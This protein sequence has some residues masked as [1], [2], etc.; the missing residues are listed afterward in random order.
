[1]MMMNGKITVFHEIPMKLAVDG[2]FSRKA[3]WWDFARHLDRLDAVLFTRI[4]NCSV[5]GMASVLHRKATASVYPQIGHFF[6]NLEERRALASPDGDKDSDPLLVSLLQTGSDM[7]TDLRHLNLKPQLCYRSPDPINLY[8]KVGHG[9]LDMYVL[10]PSKDSKYVREFLKRWHNSEQKLFEGASISGQF[11]FPI[12]NLVSI[13]A[14]LVWRPANPDDTITR[15]MFPG[16]TPQHK[17]FEGL[18]KLRHL[19]FLQHPSYTGRQML[20]TAPATT[21]TTVT[22]S[23]KPSKQPLTKV[24]KERSIISERKDEKA[25]DT[26][27]ITSKVIKDETDSKNIIDNKLLSE[28]VDGYD[29]KIE[30][31]LHEAINARVDTKL[32]D[33]F[34]QYESTV[35]DGL[36][37]KKDLK[38]KVT[39]K[40]SKRT[41][42]TD[43][44]KDNILK[45]SELKKPEIDKPKT[46]LRKKHEKTKTDTSTTMIKSKLS[47]RTAMKSSDKKIT[48][49]TIDRKGTLDDKKSPPTTP[50]KIVDM[51]AVPTPLPV[52]DKVRVKTR[53]VSP[54]STPAKSTKEAN[55]RRVVESKYKQGSPKRDLTQKTQDKK[56]PKIKRE[57][58]SRRPRPIASPIK[59]MKALKSPSK[60][61]KTM[62]ADTSKLKGLQRVNYEDILKEAKKS[63]EDTSKSL[64]DIKQ[65]ELDEREEQEIVREI[66][67]V[68]NRDSE[69]EEKNEFVGRSDIEKI[70]CLIDDAKTETIADGDFEEE[71]LIIEKEEVDQYTE[72]SLADKEGVIEVEGEL[73]KHMKDKEESEKIKTEEHKDGVKEI[74]KTEIFIEKEAKGSESKDQ[75]ISVE[76]K[77]DIS[78]EKKTSETKSGFAKPK[79]SLENIVQES[80]PDEKIST[81]IESGATTAP[82]LPE[83]E[84]IPLDDIKED[85]QVEEKH[86]KED[87]KEIMHQQALIGFHRPVSIEK[88][89]KKEPQPTPIREI[90]KTPDEVADLPLHEEVDYRIY[91]EKKTPGEEDYK[92]KHDIGFQ[93]GI[94]VPND[95]PLFDKESSVP[96]KTIQDDIIVQTAQRP[97]HAELVTVTPGSAPESPMYHEQIKMTILSGQELEPVKEYDSSAFNYG[98]YTEKLRETHITTVHSPIKDDLALTEEIAS[99]PVK[100]PSIPE[101]VE[102]EIEE[103]SKL[104][105]SEKPLLSP[106][107][108]E[109]IVADVAE[110]LKSDKSLDELIAEKSPM[111]RKS[112]EIFSSFN[113][114]D[115]AVE[116]IL[117]SE[118]DITGEK[119]PIKDIKFTKTAE[120]V[121]EEKIKDELPA[122]D[123]LEEDQRIGKEISP[124]RSLTS[125]DI[126]DL[127][128]KTVL[129]ESKRVKR[130]TK[131]DKEKDKALETTTKSSTQVNGFGANA[132]KHVQTNYGLDDSKSEIKLSVTLDSAKTLEKLEEKIAD[133]KKKEEKTVET[134]VSAILLKDDKKEVVQKLKED[135]TIET[136]ILKQQHETDLSKALEKEPATE[137]EKHVML[138]K[139]GEI[140]D[141]SLEITTSIKNLDVLANPDIIQD[142]K[143]YPKPISFDNTLKIKSHIDSGKL[144]DK[145][146][147]SEK[148]MTKISKDGEKLSKVDDVISPEKE[149]E[150]ETTPEKEVKAT[151]PVKDV[152]QLHEDE[153][154]LEKE[155]SPP[156]EE[157]SSEKVSPEKETKSP[158]LITDKEKL[159]V[160]A[161]TL[162]KEPSPPKE[163]LSP[164]KESEREAKPEKEA[165]AP[166]PVKDVD[167]LHESQKTLEKEPSPPKEILSSEKVSPE[168]KTISPSPITEIEKLSFA[169]EQLGK[170]PSPPKD[171]ISPE[172]ESE[173][174]TTPEKEVKATTP[175][176]DVDQLHEDEKPLEK[177]P[178]PPKEEVNKDVSKLHEAEKPLEKEPSPPKE[179]LSSEKVSPEKETKSPSPI[180]EKEKLS[181]AEEPLGKEPSP[182]EAKA[183]TPV[184]DVGKLHEAK[185]PLEKEPSPPKEVVSFEK[186]SPEMKTQSLSPFT[187]KEKLHVADKTLGKEQSPPKDVL[188][189]EKESEKKAIPEKETK[190]PTPVKDVGKLHEAK[191]PLEKEPSP[192]KEV[193]SSEKGSPEKETKSPSPITEKENLSVAEEPLGKEPSP[194]KEVPRPKK[195]SE[196]EVTPEKEAKEPTSVKDVGK[197]R[198]AEIPLE[199]EPS[200]PKEVLSSEKGSP[201]KETKSPKKL[202]LAE[203]PLEMEPSPPKEVLRTEK[204]SPGKETKSPCPITEKENLSVAEEPLGKEPSPPKEVLSPEK[205]SEREAT[206]EKEAKEPT[207]VKDVGELHETEKALEKEP[208]PPT[209]VL[210]FEKVS[211]EKETKSPSPIT[212][213][214]KLP[215]AEEPL[216]K[217]PSLPKEVPRPKKESER[218]V[219]PEK[220][221]KEPTSVKAV[222]KLHES[223]KTLEKEPSTPKEVLRTEKVLPEK[224]TKSPSPITEKE[225]LPLAEKPLEMEP[226][227]P[228]E[229]LSSEKESPGKETKSPRPITEKENLSVA[230]EP[231]GKEPSPPKEVLGPEKESEREATPKKE[232]KETTPVKDVGELHETEKA[233]EKKPSPPKDVLSS[234]KV[235][236]EKETK[237]PSPITEKEKLPL[238]EEPLEKEQSLPKEVVSSEKVS[239]ENETKSPSPIMEKEKLPVA[240]APLG[241]EISP[242]KEL[243]SPEKESEKKTTPEKEAKAPTPDKDVSKLHEAE[244]P[245]EKEPSPPK[246]ALSSKKGSP[247][248]EKKSPSPILEKEKLPVAEEPLGKE[249]SPPKE[250]PGPKKES[251]REVTPEKE[252][253][254]PTSVKDVG[255]LHESPKTL[256]KEPSSQKEVL[257]SEKVS[258]EKEAKAPTPDKDVSKLHE[259]EK[260]LVKEPSPPKE[261]LSSEKV[262]P[263]KE[264]KSP[265]PIT[266]KEKLPLAEKPLEMEPKKLPVAEEPLEKEPRPPKEVLSPEK[267]LE[268]EATP[269][270]ETKLPSPIMEKENLPIAEE[271]LGKETSP[272]KEIPSP[273]KESEKEATPEKEAKAP[274]PVKDSSKLH[275]AEKPLETEPSPPKEALRSEKV[276][277]KKDKQLGKERSPPKEFLSPEKESEKEATPEKE[278]KSPSPSKDVLLPEKLSSKEVVLTEASTFLE[279]SQDDKIHG[280]DNLEKRSEKE[281]NEFEGFELFDDP[282]EETKIDTISITENGIPVK[283][284]CIVKKVT[285][286]CYN[287]SKEVKRVKVTVTTTT[288]DEYPDGNV[289]INTNE[290]ISVVDE[291]FHT[292]VLLE[293]LNEQKVSTKEVEKYQEKY[294]NEKESAQLN[295]HYSSGDS[296]IKISHRETEI[297]QSRDMNIIKPIEKRDEPDRF[298]DLNKMGGSQHLP[299]HKETHDEI[300]RNLRTSTQT[301]SVMDT[302]Q[303]L[304]EERTLTSQ[305]VSDLKKTTDSISKCD[306]VKN[307]T[308]LSEGYYAEDKNVSKTIDHSSSEDISKETSLEEKYSFERSEKSEKELVKTVKKYDE[309]GST[310]I[311]SK[312]FD[313]SF[314]STTTAID[315]ELSKDD[316]I[317]SEASDSGVH[318]ILNENDELIPAVSSHLPTDNAKQLMSSIQKAF[319]E[320]MV[321]Q[322][323]KTESVE[324]SIVCLDIERVSTPPTVPVS[325]LP[326]IPSNFQDIKMSDGVQ[327][328][329]TYDK[330]D[331]TE[332]TITKVVHVGDDVLTQKISTSTEKVPKSTKSDYEKDETTD[333][334]S[335]LETVGKIKTETDTVTKIIKEG[336][337]VV[338]QTI[339]TVTTKEVISREDGTPQNVKTTIETT[340]LSKSTDGSTTTTKDTQTLLSECSSSLKS[341]SLMDVYAKDS[342]LDKLYLDSDEKID[343]S[344]QLKDEDETI[345]RIDYMSFKDIAKM[346]HALQGDYF[347]DSDDSDDNIEDTTIN[348]DVSKRII[349]DNNIDIVETITTITKTET[350]RVDEDKKIIKTTIE[351]NTAKERPDG[352]QDVQKNVEVKTEEVLVDSGDSDLEK[353]LCEFLLYGNPE[354]SFSSKSEEII[355]DGIIVKRTILTKTI[356]THYADSNGKVQKIKTVTTVTTTDE[357]PDG[358]SRTN[359]DCS[360]NLTDVDD[361]DV[362]ETTTLTDY[363]IL[364]DQTVDVYKQEKNI[365]ID[366]KNVH[367]VIITKVITELLANKERSKK[368]VKTKTKTTTESTF[369]DGRTEVTKESKVTISDYGPNI[370]EDLPEG[371][372]P[373]EEPKVEINEEIETV[374]EN[375]ITIRRK[376]IVTVT[377]QE[378]RNDLKN[379]KRIKI[380]T[381]TVVEDEHPDGSVITKTSEK[382]STSDEVLNTGSVEQKHEEMVSEKPKL[383]PEED[384]SHIAEV[385]KEL[386]IF[387]DPEESET[388]DVKEIK[389]EELVINRTIITKIVKTKY[390][391]DHGTVKKIQTLTTI[392][393]TDK[394]P[395]GSSRISVE[396]R[397]SIDDIDEKGSRQPEELVEFSILIDKI[398]DVDNQQ[399]TVIRDGNK[400]N[401][402]INIMT[403]KEVLATKQKDKKIVKTTTETVTETKLPN[404]ITE[405]T[406]DIKV[407]VTDYND[408]LFDENLIGFTQIGEPNIQTSTEMDELIED[409]VPIKRKKTVSTIKEEY[410][411]TKIRSRKVKTTIKTTIEDE[412]P[413]G[414]VITKKSEK[415]SIGDFLLKSPSIQDEVTEVSESYIGESEIVEDTSEDS[416]IKNEIVQKGNLEI[417]RTIT[418]KTKREIL[419]SSDKDIERTRTT[420]ETITDDE[421]PHGVIETTKD[422]KITISESQKTYDSDLQA[423]LL[424]LKPTG[425]VKSSVDK[426]TKVIFTDDSK[427]INQTITTYINKEEMINNDN[428]QIAVKTVTETVT[429]NANEDGTTQINND[430]STQ[431]TYLPQGTGLDDWSPEELEEI[432]KQSLLRCDSAKDKKDEKRAINQLDLEKKVES[433]SDS[434]GKKRSPVGEITTETDTFT[435]VIKDGDSEIT[436]TITVVTT[437]EVISPEK[438]KVTV[439][440]TTVS[441]GSDGVTKTTKSTKT[442]ISEIREEFEEIIDTGESEK[443]F[444]KLSSKTGDFRS[445][446]A[447][448]DDL[449]HPGISTP[450]SDISSRESRAATHIWGTESSG[451]YYSDDDGQAS[452]SSTK[453]QIAHSPRSNLSLEL[454]TK[455][456]SHRESSHEILSGKSVLDPMSTSVYGQLPDDDSYTYS[457]H[458]PEGTEV[459]LLT[460]KPLTKMTGDILTQDK[461]KPESTKD[462]KK[463]MSDA[464]F[465]KEADEHFE[466]AIEEHKRVSGSQVISSVTGKYKFDQETDARR[467]E[468]KKEESS[469]M[470]QDVKVE[471]KKYPQASSCTSKKESKS[472]KS[473]RSELCSPLQDPIESW[474][475][476]L[477]LPSP[478]LPPP[479][480]NDGKSTPKKQLGNVT[481]A[482]KNKLNQEKSK[483][484]KRASE[485]PS[486]KKAPAPI[487]MDLTYVPHHGNSYYSAVEFFK[488]V[489][490]RYYVFSGTEPSKEIYNALLDAKKTWENKDLEVTIIPTYDTDVLGYWVTENEEA[491]EKYKIDLSP[492]AS[493]CTINLQDHETSCAA[494]RL[495]F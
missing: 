316:I 107:D 419:A 452:P 445:S 209:D 7:M 322:G 392:T 400:V 167:Q 245:L 405:V 404:G 151:T 155:P 89:P 14:L 112:P 144:D 232:A 221:A 64:D 53:K 297:C 463:T 378:Y 142:I 472:E 102:K 233:F 453:S 78:S 371:F 139:Q 65:Q 68:F 347:V 441:K 282:V 346:N 493:R 402:I 415:V 427:K 152:D 47:A 479:N 247:E 300:N 205:E 175:V 417:K 491:L 238:A 42:K 213:K 25:I 242:P 39:D 388:S 138:D 363:T 411:N 408:D 309:I 191:K 121:K 458:S 438:I 211:P 483:E 246:E 184:K 447:A 6:C 106:K 256:E 387:G 473:E 359:I 468:S 385:L 372:E 148:D 70:T 181:L 271:P 45:S 69:A 218:E 37:K 276:S 422:I 418:T 215:L 200:P 275:E 248:N 279:K 2:G 350:I 339:T 265:S 335:L 320:D 280:L 35:L 230:E 323:I 176:K 374:T 116:K 303:M 109:K 410:E 146:V 12:P 383:H 195:E 92:G 48:T 72:E 171:V 471:S 28:L 11:N 291:F 266:E 96:L 162:D 22:T 440:T 104:D 118:T 343:S 293:K 490:A 10:N 117:L 223:P 324:A 187:E 15:I 199:K 196:Q 30:S 306:L 403:T 188:S 436:Q 486:K 24:P 360:T 461:M 126:S 377:K 54:S 356:K 127:S 267:E 251:E 416:V 466:K 439:E 430:I 355:I 474:G 82:T 413:D 340:T 124:V 224:E 369:P 425:K 63:D 401:Q 310:K 193:L 442:T 85:Y 103:A 177:E 59:G 321:Q 134:S 74:T 296:A 178:S 470:L 274:T 353:I 56:E 305:N 165:K 3:C 29:K 342:K 467:Q 391:D 34:A 313:S 429:E 1:M 23:V 210:S 312:A 423:A 485:S 336:E 214:E 459:F 87:T 288:E 111:L 301:K 93:H 352:F 482:N 287:Q 219:T 338:T 348:T 18:E 283:R 185:K 43:D 203:E 122:P 119:Q 250:V 460:E 366:G 487:Y 88:S 115:K 41:D 373:S 97:S 186:V 317:V 46:E 67:A 326:K 488:R 420:I 208:S 55:N 304:H 113:I 217:E 270:K 40:K 424:G 44:V 428:N 58:I 136:S 358:S 329:V 50:K 192:P 257:R 354:K 443:S 57:P 481:V 258:P 198:E 157:V 286:C 91:D 364:E 379:L 133:L 397:Q 394:Y 150:K 318:S 263:E 204:E 62:K 299:S 8:H 433:Q 143:D 450:P 80:H 368:K 278:T 26:E 362:I 281:E 421:Y 81:T 160:V 156:K 95:L 389:H 5:A 273:E 16:S 449:D 289:R 253:K 27:P 19:E 166:T 254:E 226:S 21:T 83:D 434:V 255:K 179:A 49:A 308:S 382:I 292:K 132:Q 33:K 264:T 20:P 376:T 76:E 446:S 207:P 234:E 225:K 110:V 159:P 79:S 239:P 149:S 451:V 71:Y 140:T 390:A 351:T 137:V 101:D 398:V 222:S 51:K 437:K 182:K 325:P 235:S 141:T 86:I 341:T 84:R 349:K 135:I 212:E 332:E 190:A 476:P 395:D 108:V 375:G 61:M 330:T 284:K 367:Q 484:V 454:D 60:T 125:E 99:M 180:T 370:K 298:H 163:V 357:F 259:A 307:I 9:T 432:E 462:E 333:H 174:E 120:K 158:I 277:P 457:T 173:K 345:T 100:I 73:H 480:Q 201:E 469:L 272:P 206:P 75:S 13:C 409:G 241:K 105:I 220:E 168:K 380:T 243:L 407:A 169:E 365:I 331:G 77:Q 36:P 128:D 412:Y 231:L 90:V 319:S 477:G 448:S 129:C 465:L 261:A 337:N 478:I 475:K 311:D 435:K 494:Y 164:K 399:K 236:P 229:V 314:P 32:D 361:T 414:S 295:G 249:P 170:E 194:P 240:E 98:Q 147:S 4:N 154:P 492:S 455:L 130:Y 456:P 396:K 328:E 172:K 38:K 381:K 114:A 252:A 123:Y 285:K 52:K 393:T 464:S 66:E 268:K 260:P 495:E 216:G 189:P 444:S 431:V 406:K 315:F 183:P 294:I 94:K 344:S 386:V 334:S 489:R 153:K 426:M 145:Q 17:I 262:S 327:S 384:C 161:E 202:P 302:E 290:E 228:K 237:S 269:E 197:L 244:K 131:E 227:P 31:V